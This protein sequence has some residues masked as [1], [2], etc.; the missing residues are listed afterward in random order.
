M[1]ENIDKYI[2]KSDLFT[3]LIKN[4]IYV[5]PT[6]PILRINQLL[7]LLTALF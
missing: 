2:H 1:N 3:H 5:L 6:P 4:F 7:N